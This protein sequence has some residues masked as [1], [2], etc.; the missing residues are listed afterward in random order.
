MADERDARL[1]ELFAR[2]AAAAS[3][4]EAGAVEREI[5]SAWLATDDENVAPWIARGLA[6]MEARDLAAALQ[7]FDRVVELA[8]DYAEGWN[9]RATLHWLRGSFEE[10]VAD[11]DRTLALEP[12]HF[13]ALSGLAMI[14]EAQGRP[15]EALEALEQLLHIHPRLPQLRER[16]E[17]LTAQ[18]GE[19]I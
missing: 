13:G 4:R 19:A 3:E 11:I 2:L 7:A 5:W 1:R 12:R 15:F 9:K 14:R 6:A 10:S 16:I 17:Q 18:L 8:P